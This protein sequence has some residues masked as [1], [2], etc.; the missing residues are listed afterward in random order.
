MLLALHYPLL[1][2]ISRLLTSIAMLHLIADTLSLSPTWAVTCKLVDR[3]H[4]RHPVLARVLNVAHQVGTA[5]LNQLNVRAG[6]GVGEGG[7]G[8]NRG[9]ATV[10][11]EGTDCRHNHCV[12]IDWVCVEVQAIDGVWLDC[13]EEGG[14]MKTRWSKAGQLCCRAL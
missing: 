9:A 14:K 5:L 4:N 12:C 8:N 6:V 13:E 3:D 10:H 1:A 2:C 7:A 11:L